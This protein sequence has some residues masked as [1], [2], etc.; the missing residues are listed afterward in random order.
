MNAVASE[1]IND[2]RKY[3]DDALLMKMSLGLHRGL[4]KDS[5]NAAR[6]VLRESGNGNE[7]RMESNVHRLKV[8]YREQG[9]HAIGLEEIVKEEIR[10]RNKDGELE[11]TD[12]IG[13]RGTGAAHLGL[14]IEKYWE[15]DSLIQGSY[16]GDLRPGFYSACGVANLIQDMLEDCYKHLSP[17][18]SVE[19]LIEAVPIAIHRFFEDMIVRGLHGLDCDGIESFYPKMTVT[20]TIDPCRPLD[21]GPLKKVEAGGYESGSLKVEFSSPSKPDGRWLDLELKRRDEFRLKY[22][23]IFGFDPVWRWP[24]PKESSE[25]ETKTDAFGTSIVFKAA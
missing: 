17:R 12:P 10:K 19:L 22:D 11:P 23:K 5:T 9:W 15:S 16:Q 3:K 25:F 18:D 20:F 14:A 7:S 2:G 24:K 1:A 4:Y 21:V 8:K 13:M 6:A